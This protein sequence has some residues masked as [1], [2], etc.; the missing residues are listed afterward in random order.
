MCAD[1]NYFSTCQAPSTR[2]VR[3]GNG[4]VAHLLRKG[5]VKLKLSSENVLVLDSVFHVPDIR[6]NLNSTSLLVGKGFKIVFES[7]I[8]VI[9]RFSKFAGKGFLLDDLIH[10]SVMPSSINEISSSHTLLQNVE[11]CDA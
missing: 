5:Q 11:S 1:K 6:K 2:T 7:N 8:V 10:L 3:M 9:T 4:N